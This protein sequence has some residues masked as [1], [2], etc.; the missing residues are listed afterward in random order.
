MFEQLTEGHFVMIDGA[1]SN[2]SDWGNCSLSCGGGIQ[3]RSRTCSNPAPSGSGADCVGIN[4]DTQSCNTQTCPSGSDGTEDTDGGWSSW[5]GW[6]T[7][8]EICG[9][10]T[11]SR[12]RTC[13]NPT[14]SGNGADCVGNIFDSQSCNTQSCAGTCG[15]DQYNYNCGGNYDPLIDAAD[16]A[17]LGDVQ[18]RLMILPTGIIRLY[19]Q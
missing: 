4:S 11:Q 1:W 16:N 15:T 8:S 5:S 10:G 9:G 18:I 2:W 14:P 6:D 17:D 12:S 7:C 3:S 19:S 13:D